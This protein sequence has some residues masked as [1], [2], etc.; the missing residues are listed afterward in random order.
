MGRSSAA[1]DLL[2]GFSLSRIAKQ[3]TAIE[4]VETVDAAEPHIAPGTD[5]ALAASKCGFGKQR[6]FIAGQGRQQVLWR[7]SVIG[8]RGLTSDNPV[9]SCASHPQTLQ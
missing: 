7:L 6:S 4:A 2:D 9:N 5:A 8:S 1:L 3:D